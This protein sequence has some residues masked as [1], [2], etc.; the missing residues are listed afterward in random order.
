[1]RW[2]LLYKFSPLVETL[3]AA[4]TW[5]SDDVDDSVLPKARRAVGPGQ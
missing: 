5:L 2:L 4:V 3:Q 1:M